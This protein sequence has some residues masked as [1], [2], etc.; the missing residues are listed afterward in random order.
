MNKKPR[1]HQSAAAG[2]VSSAKMF[3]LK[4]SPVRPHVRLRAIALALR[5][6]L[7]QFG[8]FAIFDLCRSHPSF[9]RRGMSLDS[10]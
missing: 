8:S 2:V 4:S 10:D 3:G 7:R 6:R 5:A 9:S 1:S